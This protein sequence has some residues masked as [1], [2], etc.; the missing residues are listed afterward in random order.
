[1]PVSEVL[2]GFPFPNSQGFLMQKKLRQF[3]FL[4]ELILFRAPCSPGS[5]PEIGCRFS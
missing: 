2:A 4:K 1:M 5:N 3:Q